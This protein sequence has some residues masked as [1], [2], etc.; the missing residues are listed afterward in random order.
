M[1]PL[2]EHAQGGFQIIANRERCHGLVQ[3]DDWKVKDW[4]VDQG[5]TQ[6]KEADG[7][8]EALA[9][10][11]FW[12]G[13]DINNEK[14]QLMLVMALYDLD[15][16]REFVL[17]SSFLKRFDLEPER[18]QAVKTDDVALLDLGYDWVRFGLFGQKSLKLAENAQSAGEG[19]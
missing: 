19:R 10:H 13:L 16:F 1:F 6:S 12:Q 9:A 14:I 2:D 5:A 3:G 8:Y 4:L 18:V 11:E 15:R 17:R 7:S